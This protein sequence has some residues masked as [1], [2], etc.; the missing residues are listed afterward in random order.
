[1]KQLL[2]TVLLSTLYPTTQDTDV[3]LYPYW[4]A[5][6]TQTLRIQ[7][8]YIKYE[9]DKV[10]EK[11]VNS[12]TA[13]ITVLEE[14]DTTYTMQWVYKDNV[15]ER[16]NIDEDEEDVYI[17]KRLEEMFSEVTLQYETNEYGEIKR[18][19]NLSEVLDAMTDSM[20]LLI[21]QEMDMDNE[22]AELFIEVLKEKFDAERMEDEMTRDIFNYHYYLGDS[23]PPDTTIQYL[24]TILNQLGGPSI[25]LTGAVTVKANS[26][27][28]TIEIN[29]LKKS[30][31]E[32]M[33]KS[34][35][36]TIKK[37]ETPQSDKIQKEIENTQPTI[38]D[39]ENYTYDYNFGWL[40]QYERRRIRVLGE[41]K[42]EQIIIMSETK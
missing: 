38:T 31:S 29:D 37:L 30:D 21:K 28:E 18:M 26:T 2:I 7:E 10:V 34:I 16:V 42:K 12:I 40:K 4:Q 8:G 25:P 33:I 41:S 35:S 11:D 32:G 36:E 27:N 14:T 15:V 1:M 6:D 23:F 5:G 3:S 17:D 20:N 24:D 9:G 22:D 13:V 19:L 39:I